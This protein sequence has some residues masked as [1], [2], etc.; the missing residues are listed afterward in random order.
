MAKYILTF[1]QPTSVEKVEQVRKQVVDKVG[2]HP[3]DVIV[4]PFGARLTV[5]PDLYSR[6][7]ANVNADAWD[8]AEI[9]NRKPE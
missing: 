9:A 4:L 1:D 5:V 7:P 8:E 3:E 6:K 2:A